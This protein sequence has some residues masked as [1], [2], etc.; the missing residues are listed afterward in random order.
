MTAVASLLVMDRTTLTAAL[1][2]L[3][4]RRLV[5]ITTDKFDRRARLLELTP[6]GRN[7]LARA[8]PVWTRTHAELEA[9][10]GASEP[11]R[12]RKSLGILS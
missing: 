7:T 2:P 10:L 3:Y 1:K 11:D 9:R 5:K 4:R 12:L 8:V 6:Q